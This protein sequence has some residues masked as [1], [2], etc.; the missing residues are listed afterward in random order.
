M[1][2]SIIG[3]VLSIAVL[4]ILLTGC[5]DEPDPTPS[6]GAVSDTTTSSEQGVNPE[7]T[8]APTPAALPTSTATPAATATP[9]ATPTPTPI[10]RATT[11]SLTPGTVMLEAPEATAQLTAVIRDQNGRVMTGVPVTWASS[12]ERTAQVDAEGRVMAVAGGF[13]TITAR[14]GEA[15]GTSEVMVVDMDWAAG[16]VARQHVV[17][18][19]TGFSGRVDPDCTA[20]DCERARFPGDG[21]GNFGTFKAVT[22]IDLAV[23]S[24]GRSGLSGMIRRRDAFDSGRY[25]NGKVVRTY[26]DIEAAHEEGDLAVMFYVQ[27]RPESSDWQLDGDVANLRHWY[28]EGL[29][30]LQVSYGD[31]PERPDA[32]AADERLGY[33]TYGPN[34]GEEKGVTALGRAAIAEMNAIGMIVD[35]SHCSKQTTLDAAALSTKPVIATHANAE[36]LT[37]RIRN[38]DD[39][40]LRAIAGTGGVIGVTCI[41]WMLDTDGDGK[42]GMSDMIAHIEYIAELVGIDHVGISS[43]SDVNGWPEESVHYADADLAAPDRW[44]RLTAQLRARGWTEED[45]AKLLGSNFRRVFAEVLPTS[46]AKGGEPEFMPPNF[47]VAFIGDQGL[48][49][50][51]KAVLEMI[52]DEGTDMVLHSGDF[53]YYDDPDRWDQQINET[54]GDDFPY[55]ASIGNHDVPAWE[56]YQRKLQERLARNS[57]ARCT[58]DLGVNSFCTF[59]GLFFVLSGVGTI[60]SGRVSFIREALGSEEAKESLWRICSWHKNQR[61]MQVGGKKDSVGWE[62]YEECRK[63]GAIIAT[64]HEHSYSRTHLMDSFRTQ[65]IA[66]KSAVLNVDNGRSF[67]FVSGL[68]GRSIRGQD[69]QLAAK[70]WWAAVHTSAQGA[71]HGALFCVL[72]HE[73]V[74]NRGYCY[75]KDLNEVIPD[76]FGVI[77]GPAADIP[78]A[79]SFVPTASQKREVEYDYIIELPDDWIQKGEDRYSSPSPR[80]SI[81]ITSHRFRGDIDQYIQQVQDNLKEDWEDWWFTTSLFETTSVDREITDEQTTIRMR[82]RVQEAEY[83]VLDVV[84]VVLVSQI[85]PGDPQVFRIRAWMCERH[86]ASRGQLRDDVLN[87]FEVITKPVN[88]GS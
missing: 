19:V 37:P 42:A 34:E 46:G 7:P 9:T 36:A 25:A 56:G 84:D 35:C 87:S 3:L 65:S 63:G 22:G 18:A 47:K 74:E 79:S 26:A 27:R 15:L 8:H 58:G 88:G 41:G 32:T 51:S 13:A 72:N 2:K 81:I 45:L 62:P 38:K 23:D 86:V 31:G 69:D 66:S 40:E 4:A 57:G 52:R 64:G 48:G 61:L 82:Y 83:C 76:A 24:T 29:R 30:I 28:D 53:D 71:N 75:F 17:D 49:R 39:D 70:P 1:S 16:F 10:P 11:I 78:E 43:D 14:A 12:D 50:D 44:V 77:V 5:S 6:N 20:V 73:G 67:A 80:V 55:F 54:L 68:A 85:V 59:K 21:S 33:G 60:D